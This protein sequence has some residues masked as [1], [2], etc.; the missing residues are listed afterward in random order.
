MIF[1]AI[2]IIILDKKKNGIVRINRSVKRNDVYLIIL[3]L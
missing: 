3:N 2:S 1:F